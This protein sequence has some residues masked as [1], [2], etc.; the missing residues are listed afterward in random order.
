MRPARVDEGLTWRGKH[1]IKVNGRLS[2]AECVG[3]HDNTPFAAAGGGSNS[4]ASMIFPSCRRWATSRRKTARDHRISEKG[5]SKH[6]GSQYFFWPGVGKIF[7]ARE[8]LRVHRA[9][10]HMRFHVASADGSII[11]SERNHCMW[12][13]GPRPRE[14]TCMFFF[15]R[16]I[17]WVIKQAIM[18]AKMK[19]KRKRSMNRGHVFDPQTF[20]GSCEGR[21]ALSGETKCAFRQG[22]GQKRHHTCPENNEHRWQCAASRLAWGILKKA[23]RYEYPFINPEKILYEEIQPRLRLRGIPPAYEALRGVQHDFICRG[24]GAGPQCHTMMR[25][26]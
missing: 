24:G 3:S 5:G 12:Y 20:L 16:V 23:Q 7:Y 4:S 15:W 6:F 2:S 14:R 22:V 17:A 8:Y 9:S 10:L 13:R 25:C 11:R 26:L 19:E 21:R 18:A 1:S